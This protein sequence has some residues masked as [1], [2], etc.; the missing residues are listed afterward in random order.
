MENTP[1]LKT[2]L[3]SNQSVLNGKLQAKLDYIGDIQ[4]AVATNDDRRVYELLDSQK[5]NTKIRQTQNAASNRA[6][7][8]LVDD[9]QDELSHHLGQQLIQYLSEK[10]PF[11]YYEETQLGVFQLFF[12]NW[13]DRRHFGILDPLAVNFIFND[14]EYEKLARAVELSE[15]GQRYNAQVIEDTTRANEALQQI[16]AD[17]NQRDAERA[18]LMAQLA[19]SE[20]R[21][22]IF[23][24]RSQNEQREVLKE[25]LA[26][27]D[28]ADDKAKEVPELIAANNA[29]IL[30]LSKEDTILIYEKRAISDTFGSF[31]NF[32]EAVASLYETYVTYLADAQ[33]GK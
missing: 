24:N 33:G 4:N 18:Q 6:L 32:Q 14:Q 10:F 9:M 7:S 20:D 5:Y 27:L 16:V 15:A 17:Q 29:Q 25:R 26:Q 12:G 28:A 21:G 8:V 2:D 11:F 3:P 19:S 22:G 31:A 30:N 13:W 23:G 1:Y